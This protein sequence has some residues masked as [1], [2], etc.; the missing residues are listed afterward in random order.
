MPCGWEGNRRSDM[1][2]HWS[3]VA[4]FSGLLIDGLTAY[5]SE[6]ST[7]DYTPRRGNGTLNLLLT[8]PV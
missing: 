5:G 2:S 4:D 8:L 7:P 1:T 3:F 6:K